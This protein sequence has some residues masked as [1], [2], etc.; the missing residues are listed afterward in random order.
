MI[1][2]NRPLRHLAWADALLFADLAALPPEALA[3]RYS[4]SAWTVGALARHIVGGA[5]WYRYCLTGEQWTD[6]VDP[7][8][9]DDVIALGTHLAGL[10]A[11]L[12]GQAAL[13]DA[14]VEFTDEEGRR[15]AWR[16]TILTQAC[17]HSIEH[18]AQIACA[19]EACGFAPIVLD[20][21]DLWAFEAHERDVASPG[22][23]GEDSP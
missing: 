20:D 6:L 1:S 5:E 2:L 4:P 19:L 17:L 13:P 3:A 18:R 21:Y 11:D 16:S 14:M 7:A 9:P 8:G 12:L 23:G 15:T 22:G 10:D